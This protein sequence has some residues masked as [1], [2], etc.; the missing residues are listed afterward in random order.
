GF[1]WVKLNPKAHVIYKVLPDKVKQVIIHGGTKFGMGFWSHQSTELCLLATRGH[2]HRV[3]RKIDNLILA[4]VTTHS[5][6]PREAYHRMVALCGDLPRISL[7]ARPPI[8]A[9]WIGTGLD[10][11]GLDIRDALPA[12]ASNIYLPEVVPY[13]AEAQ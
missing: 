10:F 1:V 2:P 4:P 13:E 8:P 6:K 9:G 5:S 11:D 12:L 7:F 3:S